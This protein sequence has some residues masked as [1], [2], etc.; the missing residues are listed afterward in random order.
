MC[1]DEISLDISTSLAHNCFFP[2]V[3]DSDQA[4]IKSRV[5]CQKEAFENDIFDDHVVW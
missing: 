5:R 1:T 2:L 3:N 4:S